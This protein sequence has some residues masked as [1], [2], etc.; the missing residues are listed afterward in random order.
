MIND[1]ASVIRQVSREKDIDAEK[2]FAALEE[3]MASAARRF[4]KVKE[5]VARIDR[6]TGE[7]SAYTPRRVVDVMPDPLPEPV[8]PVEPLPE[9]V[10]PPPDPATL[11]LIGD[12]K[13]IVREAGAGGAVRV[14]RPGQNGGEAYEV[15]DPELGDELRIYRSTE[16]LGR[17]AAQ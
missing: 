6:E 12:A 2:M 7:I 10:E 11:V 15:E 1:L 17:I 9:G 14:F 4:Y 5:L 8:E 3:A 13:S 16:G